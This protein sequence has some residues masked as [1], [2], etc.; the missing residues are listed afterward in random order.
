MPLPGLYQKFATPPSG[1]ATAPPRPVATK[2]AAY[3][4]TTGDTA[5]DALLLVDASA[6]PITLTLPGAA[7]ASAAGGRRT[8]TVKKVDATGF[9]VTVQGSGGELIDG[10]AVATFG[11][12]YQTASFVTNGTTWD[13]L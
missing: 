9:L 10:S 1:T 3:T 8:V 6:G 2:T 4:V 11:Y 13:V 5:G 12:Q 7:A